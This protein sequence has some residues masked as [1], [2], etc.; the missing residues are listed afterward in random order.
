MHKLNTSDLLT[1]H[2]IASSTGTV[3]DSYDNALVESVNG[4]YKTKLIYSQT[5]AG[6]TEVEFATMN[7]VHWWNTKRLHETLGH[8]T[9][10]EVVNSYNQTHPKE[11]A[12][13]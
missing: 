1:G 4:L 6:V 11:L 5:W 12:P 3:G 10:I 7:R 9:P 2:G 8:Q 13:I